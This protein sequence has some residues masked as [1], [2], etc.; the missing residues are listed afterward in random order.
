METN[1]TCSD[2]SAPI[3][4][5]SKTG[6]CQ[7]CARNHMTKDPAVKGKRAA[8]YARHLADPVNRA[9]LRERNKAAART[10]WANPEYAEAMLKRLREEFQPKSLLGD[11]SYR[12]QAARLANEAKLDWCPAQYRDDYRMLK[13]SYS[14]TAKEARAIIEDMIRAEDAKLSPFERQE[15]AIARGAQLVANDKVATTPA[16]HLLTERAA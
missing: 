15:R 11:Q 5:A 3:T 1:R 2:C 9:A 7:S 13:R 6:R 16:H 12:A 4:A 10:R 8:T 14:Y